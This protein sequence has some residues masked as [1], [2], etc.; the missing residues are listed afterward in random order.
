ME[1][2]EPIIKQLVAVLEAGLPQEVIAHNA[3]ATD[4]IELDAPAQILDYM[5]VPG[6]YGG[7]LPIIGIQDLPGRFENDLQHSMEA[8]YGFGIAAV[9]QTADHRTLAWQLRRYLEVIASVIQAD[10]QLGTASLMRKAPANVLYTKFEGTE[11]GPLLGNRNPEASNAPPD[12]YRS[13]SWLIL[14]CTRQEVGG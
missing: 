14:E 7:G 3:A 4:G 11:P 6:S 1:L 5:P 9:L 10:R 8:T 13:W 12:S 2:N